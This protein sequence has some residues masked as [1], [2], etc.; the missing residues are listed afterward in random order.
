MSTT[1]ALSGLLPIRS[2]L[3]AHFRADST[4]FTSHSH[5]ADRYS[6]SVSDYSNLTRHG[7]AFEPKFVLAVLGTGVL[8]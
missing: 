8:R 6:L 1:H 7:G 5:R 4:A 2:I 3:Y